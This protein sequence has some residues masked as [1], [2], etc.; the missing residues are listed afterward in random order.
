MAT[1]LMPAWPDSSQPLSSVDLLD[2]WMGGPAT[3]RMTAPLS[4]AH[5]A[6]GAPKNI[7]PRMSRMSR[8]AFLL[9]S[10]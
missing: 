3:T 6:H 5:W 10:L 1:S 7:S 2:G 9:R 4:N 8:I